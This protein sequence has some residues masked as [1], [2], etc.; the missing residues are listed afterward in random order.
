MSKSKEEPEATETRENSEKQEPL[1]TRS[2]PRRC[3][4]MEG[5]TSNY[6]MSLPTSLRPSSIYL[7]LE[8]SKKTQVSKIRRYR[9]NYPIGKSILLY[10]ENLQNL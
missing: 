8:N 3:L 7:D 2:L 10:L 9:N 1:M 4:S 5:A 6:R